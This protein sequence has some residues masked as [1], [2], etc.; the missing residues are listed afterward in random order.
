MWIYFLLY[1][2]EHVN[3]INLLQILGV[4]KRGNLC[5]VYACAASLWCTERNFG[6]NYNLGLYGHVIRRHIWEDTCTKEMSWQL[7]TSNNFKMGKDCFRI[8]SFDKFIKW[9]FQSID[10]LIT[11]NLRAY[12]I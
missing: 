6:T 9:S 10:Q 5:L 7:D 11:C 3:L 1:K 8:S 2:Y 12:L 4:Y